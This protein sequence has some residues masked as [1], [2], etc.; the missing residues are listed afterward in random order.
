MRL[1]DS[2]IRRCLEEG[3]IKIDP[4]LEDRAFQPTS[5]DL[6]LSSVL[7]LY[8]RESCIIDPEKGHLTREVSVDGYYDLPAGE[9]VL[10]S[11]IERVELPVDLVSVVEGKSSLGRLGLAVHITAGFIDPG[12]QG[13]IT[14]ELKNVNH[15]PIRLHVGMAICQL[16]FERIDGVVDRPYGSA[17]LGSRYQGSQGTVGA[18]GNWSDDEGERGA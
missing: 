15:H 3:R 10:G 18:K 13:N 5:I 8:Q 11:T 16:C 7:R 14:L 9:F 17:G 6:H 1:S 12:F 2:T 4:T